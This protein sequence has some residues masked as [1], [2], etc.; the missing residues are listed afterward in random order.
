MF[1]VLNIIWKIELN[2]QNRTRA[3]R[4]HVGDQTGR[5]EAGAGRVAVLQS[6]AESSAQPITARVGSD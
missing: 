6:G 2:W 5:D 4:A 3:N 1:N